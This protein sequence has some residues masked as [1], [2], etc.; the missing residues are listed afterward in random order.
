MR[1]RTMQKILLYAVIFAAGGLA[2]SALLVWKID[3][4]HTAVFS[5]KEETARKSE[6]ETM[7]EE[8]VDISSYEP[9]KDEEGAWYT[10]YHFISHSGG[11]LTGSIIPIQKK[12][13]NSP[14]KKETGCLTR[15]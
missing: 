4:V 13:G 14:T 3:G 15:T 6:M 5:Y 12:P 11:V 10:K 8:T 9:L 1:K 2:V 7:H